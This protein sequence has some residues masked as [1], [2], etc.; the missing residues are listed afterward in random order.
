[1]RIWVREVFLF[2]LQYQTIL[3]DQDRLNLMTFLLHVK[4]AYCT[5]LAVRQKR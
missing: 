3:Q 1:M 5:Y 4:G 2:Y